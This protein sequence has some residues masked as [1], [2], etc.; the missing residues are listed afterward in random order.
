MDS[1][2]KGWVVVGRRLLCI[3]RGMNMQVC[4]YAQGITVFYLVTGAGSKCGVQV[5]PTLIKS[6]PSGSNSVSDIRREAQKC[7]GRG[8]CTINVNGWSVNCNKLLLLNG[9]SFDCPR[10]ENS[11][12]DVSQSQTVVF[13]WAGCCGILCVANGFYTSCRLF[14]GNRVIT[15][16]DFILSG[17]NFNLDD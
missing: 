12:V 11:S 14:H 6:G 1:V 8:W 15:R 10:F 2:D 9:H 4:L 7:R 3:K 17:I 13:Q 16:C 5:V